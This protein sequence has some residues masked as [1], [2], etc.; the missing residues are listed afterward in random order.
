MRE[1]MLPA[2]LG[3]LA[4]RCS[5]LFLA[6]L[7]PL[8]A[9]AQEAWAAGRSPVRAGYQAPYLYLGNSAADD[10][11]GGH[12]D[13]LQGIANG[14]RHWYFS[15]YD[16][17]QGYLYRVSYSEHLGHKFSFDRLELT[18][19]VDLGRYPDCNPVRD[20]G[21]FRVSCLHPG[22]IDY[23][24]QDGRGWIV[25]AHECEVWESGRGSSKIRDTA[26]LGFYPDDAFGTPAEAIEPHA[27]AVLDGWQ[28][29]LPA[30]AVRKNG[31]VVTTNGGSKSRDLM[32]EY[33]IPWRAVAA[34][35][36]LN[37][38]VTR[39]NPAGPK[40]IRLV[41]EDGASPFLAD[42]WRQGFDLSDDES[43]LFLLTG[44]SCMVQSCD[45]ARLNVFEAAGGT[46]KFLRRSSHH[47]RPFWF[48]VECCGQEPE[49]VS[50]YDLSNV[51]DL[52]PQMKRGQL[53]AILLG[54]K[55][56]GGKL[57]GAKDS[58]WIKH[59]TSIVEVARGETLADVVDRKWKREGV[60]DGS[61]LAL[62]RGVYSGPV[63]LRKR[64]RVVTRDGPA[65]IGR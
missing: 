51:T 9:A 6:I 7:L 31:V 64:V 35:G 43:L 18:A 54:N 47:D 22:D 40:E 55:Y 37:G 62:E 44:K 56:V 17:H 58:V 20:S 12:Y 33:E 42:D 34:G 30:V 26:L 1:W 36:C 24:E 28:H 2:A 60:W 4:S 3:R 19:A 52:H 45:A 46:W 32:L 57:A 16:E 48:K 29:K 21:D 10:D 41:R 5:L 27:F 13:L 38:E 59:F 50:Y 39:M 15:R 63:T 14:P 53:H 65:L 25:V 61:V 8:E 11:R 49:G 23:H